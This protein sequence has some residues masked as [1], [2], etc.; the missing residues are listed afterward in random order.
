M[1]DELEKVA[2]PRDAG[3]ITAQDNER[4]KD[5]LALLALARRCTSIPR[6]LSL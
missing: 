6:V 1:T 5:T 2:A 3:I 4:A